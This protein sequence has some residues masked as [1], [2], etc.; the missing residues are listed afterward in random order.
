MTESNR[1]K[2]RPRNNIIMIQIDDAQFQWDTVTTKTSKSKGKSKNIE[3]N[4]NF[5][6]NVKEFVVPRHQ[7]IGVT[8]DKNMGKSTLLY[9]I[10]GHTN[11]IKGSIDGKFR[12]R[13]TSIFFPKIPFLHPGSIKSNIIMESDFDGKL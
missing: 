6:L 4:N 2:M 1:Q 10:L 3:S 12:Q 9:S 5:I 8:G 13:G 7:C 11:L